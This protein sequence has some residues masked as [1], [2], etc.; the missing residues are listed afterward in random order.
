[1]DFEKLIEFIKFEHERLLKFYD[2]SDKKELKY[3]NM[4]KI[5]EEVGELAEQ[6]LKSEKLQRKEKLAEDSG[7]IGHEFADVIITVLLL[8]EN[9]DVDIRKAL[10]EKIAKIKSR[11]Y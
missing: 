2:F 6:V 10:D 8:A 11:T 5:M 9:M 1:M 3:P 4:L 7:A